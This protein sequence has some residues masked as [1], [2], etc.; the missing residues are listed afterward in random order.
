MKSISIL[1]F[2]LFILFSKHVNA[3]ITTKSA[4]LEHGFGIADPELIDQYM[5]TVDGIAGNA[6]DRLQSQNIKPYMMPVRRVGTNGNELC[7][8]VANCLEFYINLNANYKANLSP[9]FIS[10]S[11]NNNG[12]RIN[13]EQAFKFLLNEGTVSAAIMPFNATTITS[14]VYATQK[15]K[16]T[17]YLHIFS[18]LVK[19]RQRIFEARKALLRGN[20][21]LVDLEANPSIR[22]ANDKNYLECANGGARFSFIVVGFDETKEH[23]ELMSC[24]GTDW[25]ND[26]YIF[27][28][29]EEFSKFAHNGYVLVP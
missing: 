18:D 22:S 7:Y 25:A 1:S 4:S 2:F 29:Y 27:I 23:F 12:N 6:R 28:K 11:L 17:N 3:Q 13:Y 15:Y 10:L 21:V 5:L 19:P 26:G 24:W 9:D 20:P 16:I 14:A 8:M